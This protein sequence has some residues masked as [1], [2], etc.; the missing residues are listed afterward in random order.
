VKEEKMALLFSSNDIERASALVAAAPMSFS[1]WINL[2]ST[3]SNSKLMGITSSTSAHSSEFSISFL[4]SD[5]KVRCFISNDAGSTTDNTAV[6]A[7]TLAASTWYHVAC[8]FAS[9]TSR[10]VYLN[11]T[12]GTTSVVSVT[13]GTCDFTCIGAV[14]VNGAYSYSTATIAFPA[15]WN[16]A[17][18]ATDITTLANALGP[19]RVHSGSLV[20][21]ARLTGG[22]N[23]EGDIKGGSWVLAHA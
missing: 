19:I 15:I 1:A 23:P 7:S 9:A 3:G 22:N 11:G 12:A 20:S 18:T 5:A 6:S 17:L 14:K 10:T 4:T 21:Y 2:T 8:V 16:V 13:P